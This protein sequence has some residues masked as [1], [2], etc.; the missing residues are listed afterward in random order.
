[1]EIKPQS[2]HHHQFFFPFLFF[3]FSSPIRFYQ[4]TSHVGKFIPPVSC[5]FLFISFL[6]PLSC[7]ISVRSRSLS[8]LPGQYI[9]ILW[10]GN[11]LH[12]YWD[13]TPFSLGAFSFPEHLSQLLIEYFIREKRNLLSSPFL[14]VPLAPPPNHHTTN[15]RTH[16][17]VLSSNRACHQII[18]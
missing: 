8:V 7:L 9:V 15:P 16:H 4:T 2:S 12:Y 10:G 11:T 1:M 17:N 18:C 6:L 5:Q 14:F 13:A 3:L